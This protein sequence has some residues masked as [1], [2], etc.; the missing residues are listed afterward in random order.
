M[1]TL[2]F[3]S[4]I[5]KTYSSVRKFSY[6]EKRNPLISESKVNEFLD[7]ILVF[8][9]ELDVRSNKLD[10]INEKIERVTWFKNIDDDILIL[11]NDLIS[12]AKDL[13][14]SLL[15]QY[16]AMDK[17]RT[18]GI[19]K[20]EITNFKNALDD[21]KELAEDLESVFFYLPEMPDFR[22]ITQKLSLL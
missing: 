9:K 4:E 1:Q 2:H 20:E 6:E 16:I 18:Q 19:A 14:S 3:K 10:E 11:I 15:R 17:I 22:E 7:A 13:H 8:K 12:V 21:L 5:K